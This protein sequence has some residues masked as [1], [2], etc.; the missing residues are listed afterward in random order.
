MKIIFTS[1]LLLLTAVQSFSQDRYFLNAGTSYT[2]KGEG[3]GYYLG[4]SVEQ[5]TS[6]KS[7]F[8]LE[9]QYLSLIG[10]NRKSNSIN[11]YVYYNIQPFK[12][13]KLKALAGF[14]YG[15]ITSNKEEVGDSV[16]KSRGVRFG[17]N[18]GLSYEIKRFTVVGRYTHSIDG[19][20]LFKESVL[21]GANYRIKK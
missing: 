9:A 3:F 4:A 21:I 13:I 18:T 5:R 1:I 12:K 15:F 7:S 14:H 20:D 2:I 17:L 6:Q 16:V 8:T 19:N 10:E 11:N